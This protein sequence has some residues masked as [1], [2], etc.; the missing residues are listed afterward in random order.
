[1]VVFDN[2]QDAGR[3]SVLHSIVQQAL[4]EI[5]QGYRLVFISR[6]E[7]PCSFAKYNV[8]GDVLNINSEL[9]AF[10]YEESVQTAT[11]IG[12]HKKSLA[13]LTRL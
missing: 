9:L 8:N 1:M 11:L 13:Y 6:E 7:P 4:Q 12:I 10:T 3:D 2:Y 5:P